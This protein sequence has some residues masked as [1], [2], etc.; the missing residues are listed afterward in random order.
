VS[1]LNVDTIK[2]A[3]GTGNLSVPAETGTVVTTASPSLG[4]RNIILN[5]SMAVAQRGTSGSVETSPSYGVDRFYGI[6]Q[7]GTL[8]W[9]QETE[10]P[11]NFKNSLKLTNSAVGSG[12]CQFV[13]K[14]EGQNMA[15]LN[16]GSSDAQT[17]T[18]SF[19]VRSSIAGDY[20]LAFRNAIPNRAYATQYT[21]NTA[22]TWE[23]K[24][25]TIV[26]DT[27]GTWATD[28]SAGMNIIW[29]L[30]SSSTTSTVDQWTA[31]TNFFATGST[32]W[33]ATNGSTFYITGVQLEVGSVA[34]P[35]EHRSFGEE[36]LACQRYY[37]SPITT[38]TSRTYTVGGRSDGTTGTVFLWPLATIMRAQPSVSQTGTGWR[39]FLYNTSA[40]STE[41]PNVLNY[42]TNAP[43]LS[44]TVGGFSGFT[45]NRSLNMCPDS[46]TELSFDAEL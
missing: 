24:T 6:K 33:F 14:I 35:F 9:S 32:N 7:T 36:L 10:A 22:D 2:K 29:G 44:L 12:F 23:K 40:G 5:G 45:D 37:Q 20:A 31:T 25:V 41:G 11:A 16:F 19:Y 8:G 15:H 39:A 38:N 43:F 34:T 27:S 1:Q 30:G 42:S 13:Q 3:D 28:N 17:I 21:I 46:L 4:R 26:G 18:L